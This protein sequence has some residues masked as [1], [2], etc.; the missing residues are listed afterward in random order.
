MPLFLVRRWVELPLGVS[1]ENRPP[2]PE[3]L[4]TPEGDFLGIYSHAEVPDPESI[5]SSPRHC[6]GGQPGRCSCL[7]LPRFIQV[8]MSR[9]PKHFRMFLFCNPTPMQ[10]MRGPREKWPC[11][12]PRGAGLRGAVLLPCSQYAKWSR[13]LQGSPRGGAWRGALP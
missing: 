4:L 7:P 9:F 3:P 1:G 2:S 12:D 13:L 5:S 6:P 10:T 11:G 8:H